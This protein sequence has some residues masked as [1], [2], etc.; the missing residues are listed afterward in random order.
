[1]TLEERI[2]RLERQNRWLKYAA[3]VLV[4]LFVTLGQSKPQDEPAAR[5]VQ[6]V[7]KKKDCLGSEENLGDGLFHPN[8]LLFGVEVTVEDLYIIE[9]GTVRIG[10]IDLNQPPRRRRLSG[11]GPMEKQKPAQFIL[12]CVV[13]KIV[14]AQK[15]QDALKLREG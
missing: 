7:I 4:G 15:Q 14:F 13:G 6:L 12:G 5:I 2:V 11:L 1:M 9:R 8:V 10:E 3:V